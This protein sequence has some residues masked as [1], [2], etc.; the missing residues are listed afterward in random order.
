MLKTFQENE[1]EASFSNEIQQ[2]AINELEQGEIIYFPN[3]A[4]SLAPEECYFLSPDHADPRQKILVINQ[5]KVSY[6][7]FNV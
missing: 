6:G 4:F 2:D 7:A 1:W 3:L 5:L